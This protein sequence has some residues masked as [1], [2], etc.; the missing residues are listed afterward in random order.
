MTDT[1]PSG[2]TTGEEVC[3]LR[4]CFDAGS[5]VCL[6]AGNATAKARFGYDIEAEAL[7]LSA[8]TQACL[9]Y[10][11]AWYDTSIDWDDPGCPIGRW[12]QEERSRF[13]AAARECLAMLRQELPGPA[14]EVIDE[15]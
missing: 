6:W 9:R 4:Y 11:V 8:N 14:F 7:P 1:E 12:S 13:Q 10:L 15:S 3:Q 2:M 5:G